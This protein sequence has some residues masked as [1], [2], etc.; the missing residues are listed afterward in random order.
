M[1]RIN[2]KRDGLLPLVSFARTLALR[3]GS[4]SRATPERL[5]DAVASGRLSEGDAGK[6][7]ELQKMLLTLILDQ[8]LRDLEEGVPTGSSI[9]I[10]RL[11]RKQYADLIR[12]LK[13]LDTMVREMQSL[14]A[15]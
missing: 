3:I 5:H 9:E 6:L 15:G 10:K 12:G 8:Q 1:G 11:S 2:L 13:H 4:T 7:V 14:V